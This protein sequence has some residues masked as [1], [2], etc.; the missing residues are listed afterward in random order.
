M[1][2]LGIDPGLALTGWAIV[3]FDDSKPNVVDYGCIVTQKGLSV[4][5]R[6]TEIYDDMMELLDRFKPDFAGM[7]TLV[8]AQNVTTGIPVGEARGVVLLALQKNFVPLTELFPS[9]IKMSI[10]GYGRAKKEQV[11]ENVKM[12]CGFDSIPKPDDAAD[13]IAI[14]ITTEVV[15]GKKFVSLE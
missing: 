15:V 3:D 14:A 1:R 4:Q 13:A 5:E 2:I 7:E 11:Q 8:F 10:T 6:V 12:L 9:Q